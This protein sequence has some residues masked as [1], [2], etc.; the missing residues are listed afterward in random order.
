M[1][2]KLYKNKE[3]SPSKCQSSSTYYLNYH[4]L[5][6]NY[7]YHL[8]LHVVK[9]IF[10][11]NSCKECLALQ[12]PKNI[13][14]CAWKLSLI[15]GNYALKIDGGRQKDR[16]TKDWVGEGMHGRRIRMEWMQGKVNTNIVFVWPLWWKL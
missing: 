15:K 14:F 9:Y 7:Q 11:W 3:E 13:F 2:K 12:N 8:Q 10:H 4:L 5:H 1:K 6:P 16:Q